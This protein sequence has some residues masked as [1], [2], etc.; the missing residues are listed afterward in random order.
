MPMARRPT[1]EATAMPAMTISRIV[2]VTAEPVMN[3]RT[4]QHATT[5]PAI[6]QRC[7]LR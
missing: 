3:S 4:S 1:T 2:D 7:L 5:P 6:A